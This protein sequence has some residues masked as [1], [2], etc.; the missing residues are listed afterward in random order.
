MK[1]IVCIIIVSFLVTGLSVD[2]SRASVSGLTLLKR[3][4]Q[5]TPKRFLRYWKNPAA[6]EPVYNTY[7]WVPQIQFDVLGPLPG[8][9]KLYVEFDMPDGKPWVKY[10]MFTP[11]LEDDVAETI[12]ME[13]WSDD[14]WEKK[15]ILNEGVFPFRIK[16]KDG[17]SG[18]ESTLFTGKFKVGTYLLDQKI[19]DYKGKK[20]FYVDYDW[21]LPLAYVWLNPRSDEDVPQLSTQV[22]FRGA[23]DSAKLEAYLLFNGKE[24]AKQPGSS[25]SQQQVFTSGA[26]EPSHR[27]AIWEITFPLVRG[28]NHSQS[29]NDYSSSFFLDKNPGEYEIRITR[30][31]QPARS[32]KF[33]V[34]AD[35]KI[36]D[37]GFARTA[38]LG[39]VRMI[40]PAKV[41]GAGDGAYNAAA[42][43]TE[44]LFG[45][46]PSGFTVP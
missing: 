34:G 26:D 33:T 30:D 8:G 41:L 45:N 31:G 24:V 7:S 21:H 23:V 19:P 3:T 35:G 28:F 11:S 29:N 2:R 13:S 39:G 40:M 17:G 46:P 15:A 9:S 20:D 25:Y 5:V 42:W 22:C 38:N 6:A 43:Q 14:A 18:A 36:V 44:A 10:D 27:W 16:L 32:I 4:V 1:K 37:N 12:R